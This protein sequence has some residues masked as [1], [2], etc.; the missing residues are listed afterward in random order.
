M[1]ELIRNTIEKLLMKEYHCS[2]IELNG[3]ETIYSVNPHA[4][5]PYVKIM[6]YKD[7]V[8]V[9]TSKNLHLKIRALLQGK[10]TDEIFELPFVYGQTIHYVP[11]VDHAG[12]TSPLS[13]YA[14]ELLFDEDIL[15]FN[16]LTGFENALEFDEHGATPTKAIYIAKDNRKIIGIAGAERSPIEGAW[17]LGVEVAEEYR[18]GGLAT[19][20]VS[21]LTQELL[22]RNIVPFYS[23]S[24]TNIGSQMVASRCG[25]IPL[26]VDTFGTILDGGSVYND[27]IKGI[28]TKF[29]Q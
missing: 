13:T 9:C 20:L 22:S 11:S 6:A 21:L 23:A 3:K 25:F 5:Q 24:V 7:C 19:H 1:K 15:S 29:L 28:T 8:V 4:Q 12:H 2:L 26:W 18:K 14:Y 16:G 17:E 10:N 27:I